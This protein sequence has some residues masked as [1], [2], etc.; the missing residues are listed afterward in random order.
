MVV[1]SSCDV[2]KSGTDL[3]KTMLTKVSSIVFA[4]MILNHME[5]PNEPDDLEELC[6][7]IG[8]I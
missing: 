7:E 3:I 2:K 4:A 5:N 6:N 1:T 8:K